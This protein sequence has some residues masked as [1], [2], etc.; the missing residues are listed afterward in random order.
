MLILSNIINFAQGRTP[1][2]FY[3]LVDFLTNNNY[4]D[5]SP[6]DALGKEYATFISHNNTPTSRIDLLWFP[7]SMLSSTFCFSQIWTLPSAKL[8]PNAAA[9]LDHRC[10]ISYFNKHLLL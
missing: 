3:K 8:A 4:V 5:Q 10:I 6:R 1:K 9:K 2:P 7:D